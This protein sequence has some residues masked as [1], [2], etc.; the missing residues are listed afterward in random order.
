MQFSIGD[1]VVHPHYGPGRIIGAEEREFL[2]G[3]KLYYE[4]D[5]PVQELIVYLPRGTM[6]EIGVRPAM[7][8]ARFPRVLARLKSKP[9]HLPKDFKKRQEEVW[10]RLS[11][12]RVMPLAEVVRDLLWHQEREHLTKK[13]GD[14]LAQARTRLAAEMALVSGADAADMEKM[15]Q[16]TLSTA[17]SKTVERERRHQKLVQVTG[18]PGGKKTGS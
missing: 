6:Q 15:I 1:R 8:R 13:D 10:E 9:R 18:L 3:E 12:G 2:D 17:I 14:Y 7:S 11:T 4:I 5:I 16:E